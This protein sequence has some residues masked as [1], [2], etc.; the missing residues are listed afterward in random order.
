M[1]VFK[2]I[3][4]TTRIN[5][6]TNGSFSFL[7]QFISIKVISKLFFPLYIML[8]PFFAWKLMGSWWNHSGSL[9][10][11]EHVETRSGTTPWV[12][13]H[14]TQLHLILATLSCSELDDSSTLL[15]WGFRMYLRRCRTASWIPSPKL[16]ASPSHWSQAITVQNCPFYAAWT[17]TD[18]WPSMWVSFE[19]N[20]Q[21]I[22]CTYCAFPL[23]KMCFLE[24]LES[25]R[26]VCRLL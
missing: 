4:A 25:G 14:G 16:G 22:T 10:G 6:S 11:T 13:T 5:S 3:I 7:F 8:L 24:R 15:Q 17:L 19:T 23:V 12:G 1:N 18:G 9:L 20:K 21:E 2:V 26:E